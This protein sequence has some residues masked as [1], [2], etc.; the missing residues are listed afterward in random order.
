MEWHYRI[1]EF[2]VGLSDLSKDALH[3]HIA[4]LLYLGACVLF[5]WK[6]RDARPW[7]LVLTIALVN[8][9]LDLRYRYAITQELL[10]PDSVHDMLN[11]MA[12]PTALFLVARCTTIFDSRRGAQS[13]SEAETP[14]S[15]EHDI[16]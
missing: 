8:E 1:K 11:T 14:E 13:G 12:L 7:L 16:R 6:V 9:A 3:V 15:I 2:L 10:W 4:V 5:R